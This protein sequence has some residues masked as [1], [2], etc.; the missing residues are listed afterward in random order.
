MNTVSNL[1]GN[2]GD[3]QKKI[4]L[5]A[6]AIIALMLLFPPKV[7]FN[8]NPIFNVTQTQS[9]GYQFLFSDPS[10]EQKQAARL[11]MGDEVDKYVGS[12]IEW[13]KLFLQLLVVGGVAVAAS[14]YLASPNSRRMGDSA[15]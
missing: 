5:V 4:P 12:R 3:L 8:T 2:S 14:R 9:A 15:A 1:H 7:V 6:V 11:L 10:A 13:G